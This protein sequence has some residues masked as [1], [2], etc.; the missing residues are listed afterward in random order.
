MSRLIGAMLDSKL[1]EAYRAGLQS[2]INCTQ[3]AEG[4]DD[5]VLLATLKA[6]ELAVGI[7]GEVVAKEEQRLNDEAGKP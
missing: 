4:L 7:L 5:G 2:A 3:P 6:I 1:L